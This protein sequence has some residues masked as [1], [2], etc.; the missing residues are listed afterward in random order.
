MSTRIYKL[1]GIRVRQVLAAALLVLALLLAACRFSVDT[2]IPITAE[3]VSQLERIGDITIT[4]LYGAVWPLVGPGVAVIHEERVHVYHLKELTE[5][6]LP[7]DG[8]STL[9]FSPSGDSLAVGTIN[10]KLTLWDINGEQQATL[11]GHTDEIIGITFAEGADRLATLDISKQVYLW[12]LAQ[13][14]P[15][16]VI[17]LSAWPDAAARI[18]T[19]RIS[20][21]GD[22]IA[23]L[24]V[25][26][27]PILNLWDVSAGRSVRTIKWE[28]PARPFYNFMLSPEWDMLAWIAG[29]TVQLMDVNS[30]AVGPTFTHE[31]ALSEWRFSP[32][33]RTFVTRAAETI[34][35]D[36]TGV[37][38]LWDPISGK[39]RHTLAHHDFVSAMAFSPDWK[40][41]ATATGFGE[42]RLWD[43]GDGREIAMLTGHTDTVWALEFSPNGEFIASASGDG[44]VH[45]WDAHSGQALATLTG[46]GKSYA[47]I[48]FSS[49]GDWI[50]AVAD[51]G[52]V[53]LWG[54][55]KGTVVIHGSQYVP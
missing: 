30:G 50:G 48:R 16:T 41:I 29:G 3:T 26:D 19:I 24:S 22:K 34:A 23:I 47:G 2:P 45:L 44:S 13:L 1:S 53:T 31:D 10:G 33:E 21:D 12:D 8:P 7:V 18:E 55:P 36:F 27:I 20:P 32:D 28:Q 14:I 17:D 52:N 6:L 51:D 42:M 5:H 46:S 25:D 9:A 35:G 37:V 49:N 11:S 40:Q 38:K 4:P 15:T 43:T 39:A 54:T